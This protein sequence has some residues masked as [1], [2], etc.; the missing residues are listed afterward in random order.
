[1]PEF[2]TLTLI[3]ATHG[4]PKKNE[5]EYIIKETTPLTVRP[6]AIDGYYKEFLMPWTKVY[7]G[8]ESQWITETIEEL[9]VLLA[10]GGE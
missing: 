9:E 5:A 3:N 10:R 2:I 1:M 8:D 6:S 4:N 7:I